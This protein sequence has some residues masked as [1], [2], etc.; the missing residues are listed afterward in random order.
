MN[1]VP[2]PECSR[3]M[4]YGVCMKFQ[5][6]TN[7]VIGKLGVPEDAIKLIRSF[8]HGMKA[9]IRLD[10]ALLEEFSVENGLRQGCCMAPVL[11]NHHICVRELMGWAASTDFGLTV[12][13]L[14]TRHMVAGREATDSD[15]TPI[16]ISSGEITSVDEFPHLE[17]VVAASDKMDADVEKRIAQASRAFGTLHK[18]VFS[19][20]NL[21]ETKRKIYQACVLPVLLY[22]SA[23]ECWIP[24]HLRK[25]NIKLNT[26]HH[27]CNRT[28]LSTLNRE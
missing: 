3:L 23:A 12:S 9:R 26:F 19:D 14:K 15:A 6:W 21:M 17:S 13:I 24:L 22:G 18:A 4:A 20:N 16:L 1:S 11:F 27:R 28:I 25:H 5:H 10:G 8:H 7:L 2:R